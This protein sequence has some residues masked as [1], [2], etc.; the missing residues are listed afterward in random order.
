VT[1]QRTT[2]SQKDRLYRRLRQDILT[3]ALRPGQIVVEA[4]I[5]RRFR[6]SRSPV[7][8]ALTML[9]QDG[10]VEAIARRGYLVPSVTM[11]D[12]R[13]LFELRVALEGAAAELA[14][15]RMTPAELERM[16]ALTRPPQTLLRAVK[17]HP[18]RKTMQ[19]LL[20]YNRQFHLTIARAS[21]NPRL[22]FLIERVLDDMMRMIASGYIADEHGEIVAA[23]RRGD[24]QQ[25]RQ[26]VTNHILMTQERVLKGE[27][28]RS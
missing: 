26:A 24:G 22:A 13:D 6:V 9:Q 11:S 2:R 19:T 15:V 1:A 5:A 27:G 7:R 18:D 14:A 25:A 23:F 17:D 10:L 8:E 3:L 16:D 4:E 28:L 12:V 21:R 20:D